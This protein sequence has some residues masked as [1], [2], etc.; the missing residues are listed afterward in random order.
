[1]TNYQ[2]MHNKPSSCYSL[3][4]KKE[5]KRVARA[6]ACLR[7]PERSAQRADFEVLGRPRAWETRFAREK[8]ANQSRQ[9]KCHSGG[10][11]GRPGLPQRCS[12]ALLGSPGLLWAALGCSWLL[13][14]APSPPTREPQR[15]P[16]SNPT[17]TTNMGR[18]SL[19]TAIHSEFSKQP[20][21]YHQMRLT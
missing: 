9:E 17:M 11:L 16:E 2:N 1:M 18:L 7:A 8:P 13:L 14:V 19:K 6:R 3:T 21:V 12:R 10:V 20:G 15:A 4:R 5:L